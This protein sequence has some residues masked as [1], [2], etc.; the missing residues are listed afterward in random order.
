MKIFLIHWAYQLERWCKMIWNTSRITLLKSTGRSR[1]VR[2]EA[3]IRKIKHRH[4]QLR[5]F[6]SHK[7]VSDLRLSR[8]S[9]QRIL[10]DDLKL[11]SYRKKVQLKISEDQ[12]TKRLKFANWIR[13]NFRKEDTEIFVFWWKI[14]RHR[15]TL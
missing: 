10:E 6:S 12:E 1:T 8:T 2:T 4:D 13:T 7:I 5:V 15:W 9:S 3:D 11:Q 14:V